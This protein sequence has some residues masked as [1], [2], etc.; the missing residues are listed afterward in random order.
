[1]MNYKNK[2]TEQQLQQHNEGIE[3]AA[4][5]HLNLTKDESPEHVTLKM[6][7]ARE[8]GLPYPLVAQ[9]DNSELV[10]PLSAAPLSPRFQK[11]L[12]DNTYKVPMFRDQL[13]AA[14]Q[15]VRSLVK[16]GQTRQQVVDNLN[17]LYEENGVPYPRRLSL[18]QRGYT[19]I[20]PGKY[21]K[22]G[23]ILGSIATPSDA[24]GPEEGKRVDEMWEFLRTNVGMDVDDLAGYSQLSEAGK[25]EL[26]GRLGNALQQ[27][28]ALL[29]SLI[30][31]Y[32]DQ[33]RD[34]PDWEL[35]KLVDRIANEENVDLS[36]I[37]IKRLRKGGAS[38]VDLA[39]AINLFG[40]VDFVKYAEQIKYSPETLAAIDK[41]SPIE[42]QL[43]K[44]KYLSEYG[45]EMRGRTTGAQTAQTLLNAIPFIAEVFLTKGVT[46]LAGAAGRK[47][48]LKTAISETLKSAGFNS[49][50]GGARALFTK[51]GWKGVG[52]AA[53]M[54]AAGEAK[55]LPFYA[56]RDI[57]RALDEA[58]QGPVYYMNDG[59]K[60]AIP[61]KEI[62]HIGDLIARNMLST[63]FE[64]TSE[65]VGEFLP[66]NFALGSIVLPKKWKAAMG[67]AFFSEIAEDS[68]KMA[69]ITAAFSG[70]APIEGVIGE[71]VEEYVNAGMERFST[72]L[73]TALDSK[74]LDM[75]R[76]SWFGDAD[77]RS[78]IFYSSLLMSGAFSAI[79]TASKYR[80]G[81]DALR[82]IDNHREATQRLSALPLE[83]RSTTQAQDFVTEIREDTDVS[84]QLDPEQADILFQSDPEMMSNL[85]I[86]EDVIAKAKMEGTLIDVPED[87]LIVE[88]AK[89]PAAYEAGERI[90][91]RARFQGEP[92]E[93]IMN[94]KF[95]QEILDSINHDRDRLEETRKIVYGKLELF[96]KAGLSKN[97]LR[98]ASYIIAAQVLHLQ[99]N[100]SSPEEINTAVDNLLMK[101]YKDETEFLQDKDTLTYLEA[102]VDKVAPG[103][104]EA[105]AEAP[106]AAET[107]EEVEVPEMLTPEEATEMFNAIKA[108]EEQKAAEVRR[109][110]EL[111]SKP[112]STEAPKAADQPGAP[113]MLEAQGSVPLNEAEFW[114]KYGV[115]LDEALHKVVGENI[116]EELHSAVK[117]GAFEAYG[118]RI[119]K[120]KDGAKRFESSIEG[121]VKRVVGE[122]NE[123]N[124]A[125]QEGALPQDIVAAWA[126][127]ITKRVQQWVYAPQNDGIRQYLDES[128][129]EAAAWNALGKAYKAYSE[130]KGAFDR[131]ANVSIKNA[132][133][134][135][136][137]KAV[138]RAN[139]GE[140]SLDEN[141]GEDGA[142]RADFVADTSASDPG[143]SISASEQQALIDAVTARLTEK[144]LNIWDMMQKGM[145]VED[146]VEA[147]GTSRQNVSKMVKAIRELAQE[148][149]FRL[150]G[151]RIRLQESPNSKTVKR[152]FFYAADSFAS[153]YRA[154]IGLFKGNANASTL[155]HESA[156]WLY[157]MMES[158]VAM[159]NDKGESLASQQLQN[160]FAAINKWL[161]RQKYT[162]KQGTPEWYN[163]RDEKFA[164]AFEEYI[165]NHKAPSSVVAAAFNT[166]KR[167]LTSI[168]KSCKGLPEMYG[169][170]MSK[171]ITDVF[172]SILTVD[173]IV[174]RES[175]L[176][177]ASLNVKEIFR[178]LFGASDDEM[179]DAARVA[180]DARVSINDAAEK[181]H[182]SAVRKLR[183][184]WRKAAT[185]VMQNMRVYRAWK[186]ATKS[187]KEDNRL[188]YEMLKTMAS[189][190]LADVLKELGLTKANGADPAALA[191]KLGYGSPA[192]MAA[193]I[194]T[195]LPPAEFEAAYMAKA[196]A[197]FNEDYELGAESLGT[198]AN[199]KL[200]DMLI[201]KLNEKV[202]K[203]EKRAQ[204]KMNKA[205]LRAQVGDST[206]S[207]VLSDKQSLNNLRA[208]SGELIKAFSKKDYQKALE[209]A[210]TVRR[211]LELMRQKAEVKK[212]VEVT[213]R[214]V[215]RAIRARKGYVYEPYQRAL[216]EVAYYFGISSK[217]PEAD[218][219]Y[220]RMVS[221]P[222]DIEKALGVT[223][224]E[225]ADWLFSDSVKD[226]RQMR[227]HEFLTLG[228]FVSHLY[229]SGRTF[230]D[231]G[232]R[233]F[234]GGVRDWVDR[235]VEVLDTQDHKYHN[236]KGTVGEKTAHIAR[237][238]LTWGYTLR[239]R[240]ARADKY[241]HRGKDAQ[242]G[243]L[244]ELWG[245]LNEALSRAANLMDTAERPCKEAVT[246]LY[247]LRD[248]IV[249]PQV[250]FTGKAADYYGSWT[251]EM[252][253]SACLNMGN[254][255]N[256]QRMRDGFGWTE[257]QL[258]A[259]ASCMP[260]EAWDAVQK[261]WD[262][263]A[264]DL[265][266][267]VAETFIREN[268]YSLKLVE[269]TPF[270]VRTADGATLEMAGGYYPIKYCY[271]PGGKTASMA[272]ELRDFHE[273]SRSLFKKVD[274]LQARAENMRE[275]PPLK[276]S[277]GVPIR[278][279]HDAAMYA[280]TRMPL[281]VA[282]GI[283]TNTK[284]RDAFQ[285]TQS[286][287][288]YD[289]VF[290]IIANM[291]NPIPETIGVLD[292]LESWART[293]MTASA[294]MGNLRTVGM[295][296][297]SAT[298]GASELGD[299]YA[300]AVCECA[301]APLESINFV[302][303]KS[304]FMR[305]RSSY[306]DIDL[307]TKVDEF[308]S[309]LT[310]IQS[311]FAE[312]GYWG[313]HA[314]DGMVSTIL[315]VGKYRQTIAQL[316][317]N[318]GMS[319]EEIEAKA[320]AAA[321][322]FVARTQGASRSL[323]IP[324]I[325]LSRVGRLLTPFMTPANAQFNQLVED[326]GAMKAGRL[327]AG[328]AF[329]AIIG[330]LLVP[331]VLTG[332]VTYL[333]T[334]GDDDDDDANTKMWAR[335]IRDVVT[336]PFSGMPVG[337]N[338]LNFTVSNLVNRIAEGAN[339]YTG[340]LLDPGYV[341]S[342]SGLFT[343]FVQGG[344]AVT[345]G[346]W[347]RA[348]WLWAD[349][350]SAAYKMPVLRIYNHAVRVQRALGIGLFEFQEELNEAVS[351]KQ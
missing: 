165:I 57:I 245:L 62:E 251:P 152:G 229:G 317:A 112:K 78:V 274:S 107:A 41:D 71:M 109:V 328:E 265:Q 212:K 242:P 303:N 319:D 312:I 307:Q 138:R 219:N 49:W 16:S 335:I 43:A 12:A 268:Y 277:M 192:E 350:F 154:I 181:A 324:P 135:E 96:G 151:T 226:Y 87:Q 149:T 253:I 84:I 66:S 92:L 160:E 63:Y 170:E 327:S 279:I 102:I 298:T 108:A 83:Q 308:S 228:D 50:K 304:A 205:D 52:A 238:F 172:D 285:Q 101:V 118:Y 291:A 178:M 45:L 85:G 345:Q 272:D 199:I 8:M 200:L 342:A 349:V 137:R 59:V 203:D 340:D 169:F 2:D 94:T 252:V 185:G 237:R 153:S 91:A 249:M 297:T 233:S 240:F 247:A 6:D 194:S 191:S 202:S 310:K 254:A 239:T 234:W 347:A 70:A 329:A 119:E 61:E 133:T 141:I 318:E 5:F 341:E 130:G 346:D 288:A 156:H 148:E 231:E 299:F 139:R 161:D 90:M 255:V 193:D 157:K 127:R 34:L 36:G 241:A 19:E 338:A 164:R 167:L 201:E 293:V 163:E 282:L 313:M 321:D 215:K 210:E 77:E 99:D 32:G 197:K 325:R 316:K 243:P 213:L 144:Q 244:M 332:A 120:Y 315:W 296:F 208:A 158:M 51:E 7:K 301:S 67:R 159:R 44:I 180:N 1:M 305:N 69:Q 24:M 97:A 122:F 177:E 56:P 82:Y 3:A 183:P 187:E 290:N 289:D 218:K 131:L 115:K 222:G 278:H 174:K 98:A 20:S 198:K 55:R 111:F 184:V 21:L 89:S 54:V 267:K 116:S 189:P 103:G 93:D 136:A 121:V 188:D 220:R 173:E 76:E 113:L 162:A 323:D 35:R 143:S 195:A 15:L 114:S 209:H 216:R 88:Q 39:Q 11:Y 18:E 256:R 269:R 302:K 230:V 23:E 117:Q 186:A 275:V 309:K 266:R 29:A 276:L 4:T 295:Q 72:I 123:S 322:G 68:A 284:F 31:G 140:T 287:E 292:S 168:Y 100:Y 182:A 176:H 142:T 257:E 42:D 27:E 13:D 132:L 271:V 246:D 263:L 175:P 280:E 126:S 53:G 223:S 25:K 26:L 204:R 105:K 339:L 22:D 343:K 33:W 217:E 104:K 146:M 261:I 190:E 179:Q 37:D 196:E 260:K 10:K 264:G 206:V 336:N 106:K 30:Q 348:T 344:T 74:A 250:A 60:V 232:K 17:E 235:A 75:G 258:T 227:V 221:R 125:T 306:F 81:L 300:S 283:I 73:G 225:W 14:D 214:K 331:A 286:Y 314:A 124:A 9:L 145:T 46:S 211:N 48:A 166:L 64:N 47:V 155:V 79:R 326:F 294:L 134:D 128:N 38:T 281:R 40:A 207:W 259:I 273:A 334:P 224:S 171:D 28:N 311:R 333:M 248:K 95:G 270:S 262:A 86:N 58:E 65:Y 320:I 110:A 129:L 236:R 351:P 337:G 147:T 330:N 80:R 150:F